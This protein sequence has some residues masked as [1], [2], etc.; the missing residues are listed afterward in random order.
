LKK[1]RYIEIFRR[2]REGKTDYHLRKK[3]VVSRLPFVT[4]RVSNKNILLQVIK[5]STKGDT[6]VESVH[7][8]QLQKF[9]WPFSRKSIPASYLCGLILGYRT[10]GKI[11]SRVIV[12]MG[13][14]PYIPGSRAAAAIKGI[15]D[16]GLKIEANA[17]TFPDDHKI[18]GEHIMEYAK[19]LKSSDS[20]LYNKRF[21]N[22]IREGLNMDELSDTFEKVKKMII[23]KKGVLE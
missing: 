21:S 18:K 11:D 14:E 2:R 12:Y 8:R 22:Y 9:D 5:A 6:V 17:K 19:N 15:V 7:S 4:I 10:G 23:E 13:V 1:V 20:D 3:I 16:S